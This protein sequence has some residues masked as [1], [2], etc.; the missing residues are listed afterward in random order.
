MNKLTRASEEMSKNLNDKYERDITG[1]KIINQRL[2]QES[3]DMLLLQNQNQQ[4]V[5]ANRHLQAEVKEKSQA[6]DHLWSVKMAEYEN[7]SLQIRRV[8]AIQP[9]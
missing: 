8:K 6:V 4:L 7:I 3:A 9:F 1:L 5:I 2:M